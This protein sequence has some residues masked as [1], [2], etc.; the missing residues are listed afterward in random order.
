MI[1]LIIMKNTLKSTGAILA[2]IIAVFA[3]SHVTDLLLEKNR[4][5][6]LPFD[7]NPLWLK[8]FVTFYRNLYVVVSSYITAS[9][10]PHKPMKH[11]LIFGGIGLVLGIL[12]AIAMWHEPPHWYPVALI[13]LGMPC[14]WLGGKL[15]TR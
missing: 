12:G 5:M 4:L 14:A 10:A 3:L 13:L 2:G 7:S 6:N 15:K 8:V 11:A 1:L 9:L